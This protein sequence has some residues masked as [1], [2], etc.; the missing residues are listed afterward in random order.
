MSLR[1]LIFDVDGTLA[2]T[3]EVHRHAFN[4]AFEAQ[5]LP[6]YWGQRAY[7]SLLKVTGGLERIVHFIETLKTSSSERA[8]L[9]ARITDI[10]NEKTRFYT[11][12]VADGSVSLRPGIE[13]VIREARRMKLALALATSTTG[14][15][16][17]ALLAHTL[18][19]SAIGWFSVIATGEVNV[20][21]KPAPDIYRHALERLRLHPRDV[22]AFEDSANGLS[23]AKAAGIFTV[24]TPTA[25]TEHEDLS[26][27]DAMFAN[28]QDGGGLDRLSA[29]HLRWLETRREAV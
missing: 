20:P 13:A 28:L 18:G 6:W 1:G 3:E 23:A 27:A 16:V 22:I 4:A 7:G 10:H 8:Q 9:Q 19:A 5:E 21:K 26:A 17:E 29:L 14:A 24:V 25:W 2:D 15:N 11:R 12:F